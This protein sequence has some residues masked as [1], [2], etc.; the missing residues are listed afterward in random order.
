MKLTGPVKRNL[1]HIHRRLVISHRRKA[2]ESMR[3]WLARAV[4]Q[5]SGV[6][7]QQ[8]EHGY[9]MAKTEHEI[10]EHLASLPLA[11]RVWVLCKVWLENG[12]PLEELAAV[13][14][15]DP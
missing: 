3:Q 1:W 12:F 8:I 4:P 6:V 10:R 15:V 9:K 11:D 5:T 13:L 7:R 2:D 14:G